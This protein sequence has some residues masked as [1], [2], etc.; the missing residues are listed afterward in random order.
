MAASYPTSIKQ[1]LTFADQ[2]GDPTHPELTLIYAFH[3]NELHDEIIAIEKTIGTLPF[4]GLPFQT[5]NRL[6]KDLYNNKSPV[7]HF[8]HHRA[9]SANGVGN[10]HTQLL[11]T[12]GTVAATAPLG[13]VAGTNPSTLITLGQATGAGFLSPAT[14]AS[15]ITAGF[16]RCVKGRPQGLSITGGFWTGGTNPSGDVLVWY[17]DCRFRQVIGFLFC[18]CPGLPG[19]SPY[20][21]WVPGRD[22][23]KLV[24]TFPDHALLHYQQGG[25]SIYTVQAEVLFGFNRFDL[26]SAALPIL[27]DIVRRLQGVPAE[28]ILINGYTDSIGTFAYNLTLS[29][30]RANAVLNYLQP[31]VNRSDL[32]YT[33]IGNSF[34]NPVAPNTNPDGSDNPNGRALNRRVTI[35]FAFGDNPLATIGFSF[36][37]IGI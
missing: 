2:P 8:H 35:G 20:P 31:R 37:V 13:G 24:L 25:S 16:E 18:K 7:V 4:A 6:I 36:V 5:L 32:T 9:I 34:N 29:Q 26:T 1:F 10:D 14:V 23:L 28:Q 11:R 17:P 30:N 22:Y 15:M 12:D 27:D 3:I 19:A 21:T 33:S